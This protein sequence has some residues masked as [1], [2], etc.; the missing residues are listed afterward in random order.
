MDRE[1]NACGGYCRSRHRTTSG[2]RGRGYLITEQRYPPSVLSDIFGWRHALV[3]KHLFERVQL[4]RKARQTRTPIPPWWGRCHVVTE[5]A[6]RAHNR[7]SEKIFIPVHPR[8][9]HLPHNLPVPLSDTPQGVAARRG[10]RFRSR[11]GREPSSKGSAKRR[12]HQAIRAWLIGRT[13]AGERPS[14]RKTRRTCV[15]PRKNRRTRHRVE[16]V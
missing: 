5:G 7:R 11:E 14:S 13:A 1:H 8:P 9:A 3:Y 10:R 16:P 6:G 4:F 15:K 12:V 2:V